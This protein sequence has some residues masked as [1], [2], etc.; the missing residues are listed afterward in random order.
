M[1]LAQS[2]ISDYSFR[3]SQCSF[4]AR[5]DKPGECKGSTSDDDKEYR[6]LQPLL[7]AAIEKISQRFIVSHLY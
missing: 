2:V 7:D 5:S 3:F 4:A 6:G 1:F